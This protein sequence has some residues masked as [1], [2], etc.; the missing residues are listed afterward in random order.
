MELTGCKELE[1]KV[2]Q[3]NLCTFCGACTGMCPYFIAY[4]GRVI[5]RDTC[6]ISQG[7]CHNFCPRLSVDFNDVHRAIFGTSYRW[8]SLGNVL[9]VSIARSSDNAIRSK[10]QYGGVVTALISFALKEGFIDSAILTCPEHDGLPEGTLATTK[11]E[12]LL[13]ARSSYI[14]A[15]TIGAFNSAAQS[16]KK[17]RMGVVGTPC[18]IL[19]LAHMRVAPSDMQNNVKKLGLTI[20][21][22]CTWAL[23]S[24]EFIG[25]LREKVS[26]SEIKKVDIPPP[27]ANV[28]EIYTTS[29]RISVPLDEI[30]RFIRPACTYCTDMTAEFADISIGA[31]EGIEGWNTVLVRSE[32]GAE[33]LNKAKRKKILEIHTMPAQNLAHLQEAS[34]LKKKRGLKNI[35]QKTGNADDLLYLKADTKTVK[36]FLNG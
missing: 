36:E 20:G 18:Q 16:G 6:N 1:T 28:F 4:K 7:R 27:P 11:K 25:F 9:E 5:L 30:R 8:D 13:H 21:L 19:A 3:E 2:I 12:V 26:L 22:F 24:E 32:K 10:G 14:A 23:S 33:L 17:E 34:L 29:G 15:P 31:A 35:I